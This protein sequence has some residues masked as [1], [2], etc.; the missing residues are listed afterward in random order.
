MRIVNVLVISGSMGSGKTTVMGEISDLLTAGDICHAAIELDTLA[1]GHLP[2]GAEHLQSANLAAMW[3]RFAALGVSRLLVS[4]AIESHARQ[5]EIR[6]SVPGSRLTVCRLRA[7]LET[8]ERRVRLREPGMLQE[9]FVARVQVLEAALDAAGLED[10]SV[11]NDGRS[12]TD[13]AREV[14]RLAKWM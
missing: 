5:D 2:A 11:D 12:V 8:M 4:G 3:Q 9:Q 14:L 10:F 1:L 13:V 7:R 6:G